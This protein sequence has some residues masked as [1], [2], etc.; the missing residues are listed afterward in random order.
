MIVN[1]VVKT[2]YPE[3]ISIEKSLI[4]DYSQ[5]KLN[6]FADNESNLKIW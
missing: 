2:L 3:K 5:R 6:Y 1:H 4:A